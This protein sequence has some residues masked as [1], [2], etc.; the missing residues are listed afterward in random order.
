MIGTPS[1]M[2]PQQAQGSAD[3]CSPAVDIDAFGAVLHEAI[4][5]WPACCAQTVRR[6]H[7]HAMLGSQD[8]STEAK[9]EYA[10]LFE[11]AGLDPDHSAQT[12]AEAVRTRRNRDLLLA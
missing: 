6:S 8:A 12:V 1:Y 9:R 5:G 3:A 4:T 7:L 10:R 11:N 2:A